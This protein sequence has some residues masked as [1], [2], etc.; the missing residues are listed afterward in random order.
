MAAPNR[1]V[2]E[3]S[4]A[5][6]VAAT[7]PRF[8][9]PGSSRTPQDD[10]LLSRQDLVDLLDRDD[11]QSSPEPASPDRERIRALGVAAEAKLLDDA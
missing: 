9:S 3:L 10:P 1:P 4:R 6:W 8:P 2:S 5:D 7:L 11:D